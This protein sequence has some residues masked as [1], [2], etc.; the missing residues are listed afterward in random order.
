MQWL[1]DATLVIRECGD[2]L[3]WDRLFEQTEKRRLLLPVRETLLYVKEAL[4]APVP[5]ALLQKM[6]HA[7]V[8]RLERMEFRTYTNPPDGFLGWLPLFWFYYLRTA[9]SPSDGRLRARFLGFPRYLQR[10]WGME[11]L[12]DVGLHA[13]SKGVQ[14]MRRPFSAKPPG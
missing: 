3:N 10:R 9:Q 12:W 2:E 11:H 4:H 7:P 14:I 6:K 5:D 1:A 8:S 13:L